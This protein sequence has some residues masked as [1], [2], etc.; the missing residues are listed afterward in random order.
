MAGSVNK[1]I[2]IGNLGRDPESRSFPNGGKVVNLRIAT[3]ERWRDPA[4]AV[5]L[6]R[7]ATTQAPRDGKSWGT[8]GIAHFRAGEWGAADAA[9]KKASALGPVR[10]SEISV[11]AMVNWRQG[12][13]DLARRRLADFPLEPAARAQYLDKFVGRDDGKASD[14]LLDLACSVDDGGGPR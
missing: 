13:H 3:S 2:L 5:E 11:M 9:L 4:R 8:L 10:I 14:R 1:V 6:A 7:Q 12:K